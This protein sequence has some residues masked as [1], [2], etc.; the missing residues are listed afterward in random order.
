MSAVRSRLFTF[1]WAVSLV[2]LVG[3]CVLWV[4]SYF[5]GERWLWQR[6]VAIEQGSIE[7]GL[8]V[9]Y[10]FGRIRLISKNVVHK[11]TA[12]VAAAVANPRDIGRVRFKRRTTAGPAPRPL[13]VLAPHEDRSLWN[14]LGFY[15]SSNE[16]TLTLRPPS[17]MAFRGW[18]VTL[19]LW[20]PAAVLSI[21]PARWL[22][23][24]RRIRDDRARGHCHP[25]GYD[26]RATPD[27]CPECGAAA[28][29]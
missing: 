7:K 28:A 13:I 10:Q 20:F 29:R 2:L 4:R 12:V 5:I 19:P 3:V 6:S 11:G 23:R 8:T 14:S 17:G 24:A 26:L 21:L 18:S 9:Q 25:C 16:Y 1:C 15:F 27:R 22:W